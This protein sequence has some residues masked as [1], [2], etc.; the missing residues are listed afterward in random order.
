M[1]GMFDVIIVGGGPAGLSAALVLGRAR[2]R[3]MVYDSGKYRNAASHA[4]HGFLSRDGIPPSEFL[5]IAR[6]ELAR[7]PS[8]TL[9]RRRVEDAAREGAGFVVTL[10]DG[11]RAVGRKLVLATG[12]VDDLPPVK[13]AEALYGRALFHCPYCDGWELK[14]EPLAVYGRHDDRGAGLAL[15]LTQWSR[16]IVLCSD[17]PAELSKEC[18]S[19]LRRFDIVV[20]EQ[21]IACL[22][23][24]GAAGLRIVLDDGTALERRAMF[25][26][27][28]RKQST[29]LARRLGCDGYETEGCRV[30]SKVGKTH[31]PGLYVVGDASRD[32]LQV[33]VAAGE[34]CEAA[35]TINGELLRDDGVLSPS[36]APVATSPRETAARS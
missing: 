14:D 26:N 18:Q 8:V 31:V 13:G 20:H 10:D 32:V 12:V 28:G 16:K 19:R 6:G 9:V 3:V 27:T 11:Q 22:E 17:G 29:D 2:R 36:A 5:A 25:F 1:S 4:M 21:R 35:I 7:Y 30:D 33:I 23:D 24:K 34:G 15:E